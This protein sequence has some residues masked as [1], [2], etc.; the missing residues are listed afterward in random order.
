MKPKKKT[1]RVTVDWNTGSRTHKPKKGK[2][3]YDRKKQDDYS[4]DDRL[5]C[6]F[7]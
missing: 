7:V 5:F 3:S 6:I 1:H 2:G 4:K